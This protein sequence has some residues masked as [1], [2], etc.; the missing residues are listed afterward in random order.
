MGPHDLSVAPTKTALT[1]KPS[2]STV[3]AFEIED[4]RR[5]GQGS[6]SAARGSLPHDEL[7]GGRLSLQLQYVL[8]PRLN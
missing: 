3:V 2:K 1:R 6:S 5:E 8:V 7:L 4:G